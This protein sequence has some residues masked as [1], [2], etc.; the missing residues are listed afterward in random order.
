L[1]ASLSVGT[2]LTD[3]EKEFAK[4]LTERESD[5]LLKYVPAFNKVRFL[6]VFLCFHIVDIFVV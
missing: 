1:F 2:K 4:E 5:L 3:A 6:R